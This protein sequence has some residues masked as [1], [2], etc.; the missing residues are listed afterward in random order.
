MRRTSPGL[1][2]LPRTDVGDGRL[3]FLDV[4]GG[5]GSPR[6]L[7]YY[8]PAFEVRLA[9]FAAASAPAGRALDLRLDGGGVRLEIVNAS[10]QIAWQGPLQAAGEQAAAPGQRRGAYLVRV[11]S[12]AG[13]LRREYRLEIR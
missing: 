11:R 1:P 9:D 12:R 4:R 3:C 7:R 10:G 8:P 5:G 13:E 2:A 6:A